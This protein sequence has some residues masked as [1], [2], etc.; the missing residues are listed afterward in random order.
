[1]GLGRVWG[2]V[3]RRDGERER[4]RDGERERRRAARIGKVGF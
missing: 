3:A 1:M 4:R 2:V